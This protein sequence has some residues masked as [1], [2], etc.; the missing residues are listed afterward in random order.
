M[1]VLF[2]ECVD[3]FGILGNQSHPLGGILSHL[4]ARENVHVF[5][6]VTRVLME[7]YTHR[8]QSQSLTF[9]VLLAGEPEASVEVP[10]HVLV[11]ASLP[12]VV[13]GVGQ[14][15]PLYP[16]QFLLLH[17]RQCHV[18]S[19]VPWVWRGGLW[20]EK[21]QVTKSHEQKEKW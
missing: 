3:V 9:I 18:G 12:D 5:V 16:G 7:T 20:C 6:N 21:R 19:W 17:R 14:L 4:E 8:S 15:L 13:N 1:Y 10:Q 11:L 2:I